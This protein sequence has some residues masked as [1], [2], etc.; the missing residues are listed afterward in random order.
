MLSPSS[1]PTL[2]STTITS[3]CLGLDPIVFRRVDYTVAAST[4]CSHPHNSI[5]NAWF[6]LEQQRALGRSTAVFERRSIRPWRKKNTNNKTRIS[7]QE[8]GQYD[9]RGNTECLLLLAGWL[10]QLGILLAGK[11]GA[12][13]RVI[14][15]LL[16]RFI[17]PS[18]P[19]RLPHKSV[20]QQ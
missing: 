9:T 1:L 17:P 16:I 15:M 5:Q 18:L 2:F 19:V 10:R 6:P 4:I 3:P 14:R 11:S 8:G 12:K 7:L 20:S 13:A